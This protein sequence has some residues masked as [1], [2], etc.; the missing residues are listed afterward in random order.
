MNTPLSLRRIGD[1]R[2]LIMGFATLW[3]AFFHSKY[4]AF[5]DSQTLQL[6]GLAEPLAFLRTI[7]NCGVDFFLFLSGFGLY[8]SLSRDG[9]VLPFYGRRFRRVLPAT[10]I[11]SILVTA[12]NG[13]D[14][15]RTYCADAFL[16]G[17][18]L[19]GC[20]CWRFWYCSFL[21]L[22]YLLYP[23]IHRLL[24]RF[25]LAAALGLAA[26]SVALSLLLRRFAPDYFYQI[27]IGTTRIPV[28]VLGA[29]VGKRSLRGDRL[30]GWT[31]PAALLL[32]LAWL[33]FLYRLRLPAGYTFV[34]R[35]LYLPLALL[36]VL[37]L[38]W[39][40][41]HARGRCLRRVLGFFGEYSLE[42]YLIYESLYLSMR[43]VFKSSDGVGLSY[44]L[45]CFVAALL[46]SLALKRAVAVLT[47]A[48]RG[49]ES[50]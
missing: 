22:L 24:A 8:H 31:G 9:A 40:D 29:W 25:D 21:L 15:L 17:F 6:L 18:F 16:Y 1:S 13:A 36:T 43:G 12:L 27:E 11:V 49:E 10:L 30:P 44:A 48:L 2:R 50:A 45:P 3:V 28:F 20:R 34:W 7:G 46:L 38:S 26:A 39:L 14:S 41:A 32:A 33:C 23:L 4:L 35:Y 47:K 5:A 19:P 37:S 42:I